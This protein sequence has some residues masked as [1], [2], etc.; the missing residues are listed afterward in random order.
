M[1]CMLMPTPDGQPVVAVPYVPCAAH[2]NAVQ[3]LPAAC[4]CDKWGVVMQVVGLGAPA[5]LIISVFVLLSGIIGV[6]RRLRL[7]LQQ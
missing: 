5:W 7:L 3:W 2:S 6:T 4:G 1:A